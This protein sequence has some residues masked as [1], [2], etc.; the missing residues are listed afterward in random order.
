MFRSRSRRLRAVLAACAAAVLLVFPLA[1]RAEQP[2]ILCAQ[3]SQAELPMRP[4]Q[5]PTGADF[6]RQVAGMDEDDRETVI[7]DQLLSGNIPQFLRHLVPVTLAGTG[8]DGKP[9][10]IT[11]CVLPDYLAVGSDADFLLVPMRL[12]TALIV[13]GKYGYILPTA[14]MVDAIYAQSTVRLAPQPLPAGDQMRST[15]YYRHHNA[16]V[17]AQRSATSGAL[18]LL[19]AGDKKDLVI[20]KRLWTNLERVA[21]YGWHTSDYRPIQP[22]STVHGARYADYSHGVRLVSDTVYVDDTPR[23]IRALLSDPVL[24]RSLN[25]EGPIDRLT[26]L[27]ATLAAVRLPAR[28]AAAH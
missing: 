17:G 5:A 11:L 20:T 15:D 13:A 16:L 28:A 22:L 27:L 14:K 25:S 26:E 1:A 6:V 24:A 3:R 23:P 8:S 7:R 4:A 10:R 12:A 18:G 21:I 19:T 2:G 9:L